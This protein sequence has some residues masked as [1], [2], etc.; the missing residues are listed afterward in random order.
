MD[1]KDIPQIDWKQTDALISLAL[2][3]DLDTVGDAT[4][5][6][7]I[8]ENLQ[9]KA[10]FLTKEDCV[11]AGLPVAERLFK[12]IDPEL[13]WKTLVREGEFC[14]R[15]T[16]MAEVRGNARALLTGERRAQLP[17][18]ALRRGDCVKTLSGCCGCRRGEMPDS[19]HPQ[20]H[21]GLAES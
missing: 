2:S 21:S 8:P 19:R 20:D 5:N 7:V 3:E 14:P 12:T 1:K 4:T 15:G 16:I 6:S 13:E 10:V 17:A 18:K 9:A 11:C